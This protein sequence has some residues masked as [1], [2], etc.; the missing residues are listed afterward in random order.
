MSTLGSSFFEEAVRIPGFTLKAILGHG[1]V[2]RVYRAEDE[3]GREVALKV[4][5]L[6]IDETRQKRFAQEA[7]IGRLLNHPD[8]IKVYDAGTHEDNGWISMEVLEGSE[9]APA[10]RDRTFEVEDRIQVITRVAT[11]L[12]YAHGQGVIHRDVKPSN[13]FLTA[14]GGVKLLDFGIARLKANKITKTGFIVGTPQ[15]MSPE[16]ITGVAIDPRADVFSLGV[17]AYELLAGALPWSGDNHTQI[18]M[19][20][21]SKPA[22]PFDSA[23][24]NSWF[25]L[26]PED[27]RRL[28]NV[29]HRAIRQEPQHRYP[30][31][32]AF[33][34]ALQGYL[35]GEE[36]PADVGLSNVDPDAVGK[37][38]ID[39]AMARAARLKV[40][41]EAAPVS[42]L[43][44][45]VTRLE[46][47]DGA[48]NSNLLWVTL[49]IVFSAG[50]GI[51]IWMVLNA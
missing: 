32:A 14:S 18:M 34:A 22:R 21:C 30:D 9:L 45:P 44:E 1:G 31:A 42:P 47:D 50:L 2:G 49:L 5:P 6:E 27:L 11:A 41:E 23:F 48:G 38:R 26:A 46:D 28:H 7:S 19:A 16:Q 12:H 10:M 43:T 36:D 3:T 25:T 20:I 39:W 4:M 35:D 8:I 24:D 13:V 51:A 17:V 37:R 29:L 40:E 33:A 15:Y